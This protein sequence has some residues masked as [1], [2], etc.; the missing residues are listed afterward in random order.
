[1]PRSTLQSVMLSLVVGT[2]ALPVRAAPSGPPLAGTRPNILVILADDMGYSDIGC[3]GGEIH[4]PNLDRLAAGGVR[5]S[6]FYTTPKCFPSRASLLTGLY[7]HQVG[8]AEHPLKFQNC[9]TIAEALRA[10]GYHTWMT[11]KWH[12]LDVPVNRG[13]ERY[14]G[15]NDGEANH[16]NPGHQR[17]GEP[18]PA[19]DKGDRRWAIDGATYKPYTP[20]DPKFYSTDAFTDYALKYLTEQKDDAPFFLYV[21]YTAPHYP[22]QAWP[23]DI[24]KYRGRYEIGWDAVRAA[25][26]AR[27]RQMGL[28]P[29]DSELAPRGNIR[30]AFVRDLGPWLPKFWDANGDIL[31]WTAVPD[32]PRWDLKMSVYAAMVDR[33]DQD[34]GR[35]LAKL[36]ELKKDQNTLV[37]F[38]SDNGA[39]AGSHHVGADGAPPPSG[40]GPMDSFHTYD[41]PWADV[42]VAPFTGYK[43]DCYE[44]GLAVPAI[45]YWPRGIH[46]HDVITPDVAHIMDIMP[47]LLE[48]A[49]AKYPTTFQ[50]QPI[51]PEEGLSLLPILS[52]GTRAGHD[53]LYWEYKGKRAV[54]HRDWKLV[55]MPDEPW[56]LYDLR[57]DRGEMHNLVAQQPSVVR[58]LAAHWDQWAQRVGV[59]PPPARKHA[60]EDAE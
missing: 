11:G 7:P 43:D 44:G 48:V 4:T 36:H 34:I 17:P 54:R 58:D 50:G 1:M 15:L 37:I 18:K 21:A 60:K 30:L 2:G 12:G 47:T 3:Y 6:Q 27:Q 56:E 8:M 22:I 28:L 49:G 13:F 32:H 5:F 59:K 9:I 20:T 51:P 23:E 33:M 42:S 16:F 25:R 46:A 57:T 10:A 26:Y 14:F 35:L 24:A 52:G 45:F 53:Y 40:P 29:T 31:P 38:L 55:G 39:C 41:A 19:T